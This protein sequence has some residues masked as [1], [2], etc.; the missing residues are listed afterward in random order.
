MKKLLTL[1]TLLIVAVVADAVTIDGVRYTLMGNNTIKCK[2]A[3]KKALVDLV[4]PSKIEIEGLPYLVV[5]IEQEGFKGCKNLRSVTLPNTLKTIGEQAFWDCPA[6]ESV[7]LPDECDVKISKGSFGYDR[8]GVFHN[9]K[10]LKRMRGTTR[11][12]PDYFVLTALYDCNEVPAFS[13]IRS[14]DE[15]QRRA[16]TVNTSFSDFAASRVKKPSK[17][18]SAVRCMRLSL[19]GK[20]A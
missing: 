16:A 11:M 9:C 17:T 18:G 6:L 2:A 7:V 1:I 4:I 5:E 10:A 20:L 14:L 15:A 13:T 19:S 8:Y 3:D 12:Y